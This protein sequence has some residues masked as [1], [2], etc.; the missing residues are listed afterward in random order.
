MKLFD[1][2]L[3]NFINHGL[4]SH[5]LNI[6]MP[7][8]SR[9]GGGELYF[10]IGVMLLFLKKREYKIL[11]IVLLAG[12]TLSYY[13][14]GVLKVFIAR[15]RPFVALGNV[16]LLG[17]MSTTPSFPS[18]HAVGAFMIATLLASQLK[19]RTLFYSVLLYLFAVLVS[20]SRV[21]IGVHYP[22]DVLAGAV[23]GVVVGLI[24]VKIESS[25]RA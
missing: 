21:Y 10:L 17:D 22:S 2:P 5:A 16:I 25:L 15:P 6:V 1:L 13:V 8:I 3:F 24:L 19:K 9:L 18:N 4:S 23:I 7:M 14:V 20:F 12:L 11:G